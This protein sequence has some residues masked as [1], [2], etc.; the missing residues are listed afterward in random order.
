MNGAERIAAERQRQIEREGYSRQHDQGHDDHSLAMAA[1]CYASPLPIYALVEHLGGYDFS[2]PWP[3][4]SADDKRPRGGDGEGS[5]LPAM[6]RWLG[7]NAM[8]REQRVRMLEKAGALIA[9]ELD[10]LLAEG[11]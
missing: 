4:H 8:T 1:A 11:G 10:R 6:P 7:D 2:D 3:W 5:L 9:A